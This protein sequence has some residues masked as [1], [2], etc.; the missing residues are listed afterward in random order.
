MKEFKKGYIR[1]VLEQSDNALTSD[2]KGDCLEELVKSLFM[3]IPGLCLWGKNVVDEYRAQELDVV[4]END[5]RVSELYFMDPLIITECK[6]TK[7]PLGSCE[8]GWFMRKL[9]NRGNRDI[10]QLKWHYRE[11]GIG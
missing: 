4:F 11:T 5:T 1:Q 3:Q 9:Q 7:K 8:V 6:N 10:G 2:L